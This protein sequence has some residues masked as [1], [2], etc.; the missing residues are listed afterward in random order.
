MIVFRE[1]TLLERFKCLWPSYRREKDAKLE[2]AI[3]QLM[4]NP[5][6][7]C[8]IGDKFI[9]DGYGRR[10]NFENPFRPDG[11]GPFLY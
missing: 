5:K 11:S 7:P 8:I 10:S 6:L 4:E 9:P 2:E 1:M 3:R